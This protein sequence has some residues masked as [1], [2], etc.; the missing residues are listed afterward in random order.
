MSRCIRALAISVLSATF[1]VP[2]HTQSGTAPRRASFS[3]KNVISINVPQ[4]AQQVRMWMAVPQSDA[5]TTVSN[6]KISGGPPARFTED[7]RGN[8]V[9]YLEITAPATPKIELEETF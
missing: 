5:H 4:G 6:L 3:V 2:A 9:A 8:R 7:S 1:V